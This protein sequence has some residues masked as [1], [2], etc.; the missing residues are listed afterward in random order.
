[1]VQKQSGTSSGVLAI[2]AVKIWS[3]PFQTLLAN[4]L[5]VFALKYQELFFLAHQLFLQRKN[6]LLGLQ[7]KFFKVFLVHQKF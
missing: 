2:L 5:W 4:F 1:M 7:V 6:S 3:H